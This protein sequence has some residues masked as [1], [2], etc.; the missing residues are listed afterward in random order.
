MERG[1]FVLVVV[2]LRDTNDIEAVASGIVDKVRA[3]N[4]QV[5]HCRS[6]GREECGCGRQGGLCLHRLRCRQ[7]CRAIAKEGGGEC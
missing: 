1:V 3:R 2:C 6:Q 7:E 4:A 5:L